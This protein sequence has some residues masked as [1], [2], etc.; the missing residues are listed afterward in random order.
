MGVSSSNINNQCV[1]REVCEL[2]FVLRLLEYRI[3]RL[4]RCPAGSK[5]CLDIL[6]A[7]HLYGV[8]IR[9]FVNLC[10]HCS[11]FSRFGILPFGGRSTAIKL[12]SGDVWVL[13]STPLTLDT[14]AKLNELGP[15]K[16]GCCCF[17]TVVLVSNASCRQAQM[18]SRG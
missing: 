10:P 12:S 15:V 6:L 16:F 14:K 1:I 18:D 2:F 17:T 5:R 3:V 7:S 9:A 8:H 11:P 13:A 4:T